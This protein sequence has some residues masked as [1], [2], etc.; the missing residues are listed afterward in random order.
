MTMIKVSAFRWVPPFAQGLVRDLRVRWALEEA[1]LAYEERLIGPADQKSDGYRAL[2]PFGQVPS[3]EENGL[4]LFESGA[5]V[6]HIA[7]RVESLMPPEPAARARTKTWMFAALN[8]V[9]PPIVFLNAVSGTPDAEE[10]PLKQGVVGLVEQRLDSLCS[11]LSGRDYLED[12]FT[13]ADLLMTSVLR[14]LRTTTMVTDRPV[15]EFYRRRCEDRPAFKK[16][17]DA[18]MLRF[19]ENAPPS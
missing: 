17:L 14:I 3:Y 19:A 4:E 2:Q 8:T 12:H 5:I 10:S 15:L 1:G 11:Q 18:Q 16:A 7:E 13:A 9:E 6:L